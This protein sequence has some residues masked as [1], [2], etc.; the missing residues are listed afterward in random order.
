MD[1]DSVNKMFN[2]LS[3]EQQKKIQAILADKNQTEKILKSPQAQAILKKLTG[4]K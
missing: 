1:K 3:K 4:E 2:H